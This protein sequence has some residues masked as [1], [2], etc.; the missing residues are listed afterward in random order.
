VEAIALSGSAAAG[1]SDA[2][3]DLDLYV[4][5]RSKIPED[6]RND[7]IRSRAERCE[8]NNQFWETGD[9]WI[10]KGSGIPVDV[11]Y[12]DPHWI[13]DQ[14][15]RVL[16][17]H[18]ASVGYTTCFWA[19]L[20]DSEILF[21]RNSW[22]K[23]LKMSADRPYPEELRRSIVRKNYPILSANIS[24][25][26]HQ[27]EKAIARQDPVSL[28]HRVAAFLASYFDILFA[29]NRAPHPGEKRLLAIA[30]QRCLLRPP[31][32][33]LQVEALIRGVA[34]PRQAL[35]A[36]LNLIHGLDTILRIEGL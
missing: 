12:R 30:S 35:D 1:M 6:L 33:G 17:R 4:Y 21:D 9:E 24:S 27:I 29:V 28:N 7:W 34:F 32:L 3:S 10:E 36:V 5:V 14:M 18:Q 23:T 16:T 13:E 31:D 2:A 20:L 11:M 25:Y 8:I 15:D 19:N 22:L 26:A